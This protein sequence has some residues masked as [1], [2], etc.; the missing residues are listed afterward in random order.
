MFSGISLVLTIP[1]AVHRQFADDV[2]RCLTSG[3]PNHRAVM[4]H[5]IQTGGLGFRVSVCK[6]KLKLS[7]VRFGLSGFR[8][9]I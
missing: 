5:R 2:R 3:P 4:M 8:I 7:G 1:L 9:G 6:R